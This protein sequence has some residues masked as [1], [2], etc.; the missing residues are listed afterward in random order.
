MHMLFG[1]W[2]SPWPVEPIG[3]EQARLAG[4]PE[5]DKTNMALDWRQTTAYQFFAKIYAPHLGFGGDAA[6]IP[7]G[8]KG[9]KEKVEPIVKH[10]LG[11]GK[12]IGGA[13]PCIADYSLVPCL[14]LLVGSA[15]WAE[16][17]PA[18][19]A[20]VADFQGAVPSFADIGKV[21]AEFVASKALVPPAAA[22]AAEKK[23]EEV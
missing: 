12:F 16:A 19:K 23:E 4:E 14:T 7:E 9:M 1:R 18:I 3:C 6:T 13:A 8:V 17:D 2:G 21:Q 22:P 10:F 15:Y 20:Y 11:D 5:T